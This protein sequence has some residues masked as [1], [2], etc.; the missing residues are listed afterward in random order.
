MVTHF[1][2]YHI[3]MNSKEHGRQSK[4]SVN[5][6]F[7]EMTCLGFIIYFDKFSTSTWDMMGTLHNPAA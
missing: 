7:Q 1:F 5:P 3:P 6:T 4:E 2:A